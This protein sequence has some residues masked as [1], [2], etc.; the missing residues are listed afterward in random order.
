MSKDK[1]V[2]KNLRLYTFVNFYFSSIQQGIQSAHVVSE[3]FKTEVYNADNGYLS[4]DE[5]RTLSALCDWANNHKTIIV[6]NGGMTC[7]METDVHSIKNAVLHSEYAI[8]FAEFFEDPSAIGAMGG[9]YSVRTAYGMVLPEE[10]YSAEIR[11]NDLE[12]FMRGARDHNG[13]L[14]VKDDV[15]YSSG[16]M[17]SI[18]EIFFKRDSSEAVIIDLLKSKSL[19]R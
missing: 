13:V 4:D 10:L 8:P 5:A 17:Y 12:Y 11:T 9:D 6:L 7:D 14:Q 16:P 2:G 19:A 15:K 3:L 18:G 1:I